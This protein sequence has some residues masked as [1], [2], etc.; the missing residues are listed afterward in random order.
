MSPGE[1]AA[2]RRIDLQFEAVR[3]MPR[4]IPSAE[5][6]RHSIDEVGKGGYIR[7]AGQIHRV[8]EVSHYQQKKSRFYELELFGLTTGEKRYIEWEKDD[9]VEVCF[10]QPVISLREL[11]LSADDIEAMSDK[12]EG[13]ISHN[14]KTYRYEDDYQALYH[15]GGTGDGERVYMY[16]FETADERWSLT[17]E[18]WGDKEGGY[19]YEVY[20]GEDLDPDVVEVLVVGSAYAG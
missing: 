2:L 9:A 7:V 18:E 10:I 19:E 16:E 4:P 5:R 12:E 8:A 13:T 17:V 20:I 1:R 11:G 3:A 6:Y 14:G 15:R